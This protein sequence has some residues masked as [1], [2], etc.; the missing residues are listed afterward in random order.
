MLKQQYK[1]V[2]SENVTSIEVTVNKINATQQ[3]G[4]VNFEIKPSEEL[5]N[6]YQLQRRWRVGGKNPE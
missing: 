5:P 3:F 2:L 1:V 6:H 4:F